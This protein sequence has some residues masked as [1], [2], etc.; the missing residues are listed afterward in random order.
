MPALP[1]VA[2]TTDAM[3][4]QGGE[5]V[6]AAAFEWSTGVRGVRG[7]AALTWRSQSR[8]FWNCSGIPM[9]SDL[10]SAMTF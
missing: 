3:M 5:A 9:S 1:F 2:A 4:N 8:K 10:R 6:D 7:A